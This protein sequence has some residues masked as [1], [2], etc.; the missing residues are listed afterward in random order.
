M[1]TKVTHSKDQTEI[2]IELHENGNIECHDNF[3]RMDQKS[4]FKAS[5]DN[6]LNLANSITAE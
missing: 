5:A 1:N 3:F 4:K 6:T 2:Q